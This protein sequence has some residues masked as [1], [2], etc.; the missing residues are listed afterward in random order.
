MSIARKFTAAA[1]VVSATIAAPTAALASTASAVSPAGHSVSAA[2]Q[3]IRKV[4]CKSYTFN[5]RY[6][7]RREICYEGTGTIRPDI[8]NVDRITTGGNE[9][10]FCVAAR[11]FHECVSFR[12]HGSFSYRPQQHVEL[13]YLRI[14]VASRN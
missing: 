4:V 5:V 8:K 9:G 11:S 3:A 6:D 7:G 14:I 13:V 10:V 2:P 12:K 1:M